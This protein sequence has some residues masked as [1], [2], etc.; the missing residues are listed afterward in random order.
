PGTATV[1]VSTVSMPASC[2]ACATRAPEACAESSRSS[3]R[4]VDANVMASGPSAHLL[5]PSLRPGRALLG[6]SAPVEDDQLLQIGG[7]IQD[8]ARDLRRH[9]HGLVGR[10]AEELGRES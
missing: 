6:D 5:V 8:F 10:T 1:D 9:L 2:S 7:A 4:S 3:A